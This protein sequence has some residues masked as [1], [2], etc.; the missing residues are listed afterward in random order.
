MTANEQGEQSPDQAR[1][2][3]RQLGALVVRRL[4]EALGRRGDGY[5]AQVRRLWE[6]HYR[7]NLL[8]GDDA[9]STR[10]AAGYFLVVDGEGSILA[11]T[12]EITRQH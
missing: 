9:A 10:I 3:G 2:Q 4:L 6:G 5:R 12:P 8:T 1:Q 11:S 7:V